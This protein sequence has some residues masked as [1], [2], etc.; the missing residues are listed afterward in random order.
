[1]GDRDTL[2]LTFEAIYRRFAPY[3][4]AIAYKLTGRHEEAEDI[5]QEVFSQS[6]GKLTHLT[7]WSDVKAWLATVTV[8]TARR[9]LQRRRRLFFRDPVSMAELPDGRGG[10]EARAEV[11][12][13]FALLENLTADQR[14]AWVLFYG[15]E[16]GIDDIATICDV[17]R[18]TVKRRLQE[19]RVLLAEMTH[20]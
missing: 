2:A 6:V 11:R 15:Q 12:Q 13:L 1:M 8:R 19:A 20:E 5:V 14:I 9:H 4:A 17:S 18:A 16:E 10:P 3:V 7:G